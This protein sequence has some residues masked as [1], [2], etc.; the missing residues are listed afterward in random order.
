VTNAPGGGWRACSFWGSRPLSLRSGDKKSGTGL[1]S[2]RSWR[3]GWA[4]VTCPLSPEPQKP[5]LTVPVAGGSSRRLV[6][7]NSGSSCPCS[8]RDL[9]ASVLRHSVFVIFFWFFAAMGLNSGPH[10]CQ[11]AALPSEP[12]H[13]PFFVKGFLRWGLRNHFP[14]A[15]FE[16]RS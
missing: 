7:R 8:V 10:P 4:P 16:P 2:T 15:G 9:G 11:A 12:L 6:T 3:Q 1:K 5:R 14:E 13:Q